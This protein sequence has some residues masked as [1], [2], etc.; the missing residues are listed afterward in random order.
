MQSRLHSKGGRRIG[1]RLAELN[2]PIMALN[3][4]TQ[5][6]VPPPKYMSTGWSVPLPALD[7]GCGTC[8]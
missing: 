3:A 2:L 4:T 5:A 7:A 1:S 8:S 6:L